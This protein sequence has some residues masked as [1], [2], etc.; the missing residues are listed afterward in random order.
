MPA[1]TSARPGPILAEQR[2]PSR[3]RRGRPLAWVVVLAV[4]G[5]LVVS[6][7]ILGRGLVDRLGGDRCQATALENSVVF[8][9]EQT[10]NAAT[11]TAIAERRELPPR[12]ATIAIA[13][14]IQ[15]SKLRN[16]RYGDRD[17]LGLFQQ[18]P[19]QGWGTEAEVLDPD[20]AT[21]AFY[22][23]LV[24]I[25]GY[26]SMQITQV[27][28]AVQRSA[29]PEAY[30][31]HE[32]EGR[33]L[34]STLS[35]HSPAGLGCRLADPTTTDLGA[36]A[37]RLEAEL[38]VRATVEGTRAT[39]R[40]DTARHAWSVGAWA[41]ANAATSGA[42]RVQVGSKEWTRQ[43]GDDGWLWHEAAEPVDA[44]RVVISAE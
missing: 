34:A 16:L 30:A 37:Q 29:Y 42:T 22:D 24:E 40:T 9:P 15:E 31:D 18:R 43:Q 44:T 12:A 28:Q 17:S 20:H 14:A 5:A 1:P 27:A 3:R 21:N 19:S 32:L 8:D 39:A 26:E 41:V 23:A 10:A 35:G 33:L 38:G 36:M 4:L 11:I 13:T 25:D 7:Y 6:A 2:D